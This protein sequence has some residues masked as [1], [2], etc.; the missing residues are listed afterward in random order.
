MSAKVM[1]RFAACVDTVKAGEW[2]HE[3]MVREGSP[4]WLPRV[5]VNGPYEVDEGSS[6]R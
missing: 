2:R 5:V 3:D 4:T 1:N 6:V